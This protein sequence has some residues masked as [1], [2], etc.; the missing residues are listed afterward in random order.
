MV[1]LSSSQNHILTELSNSML[2]LPPPN[3]AALVTS[4]TTNS[5]HPAGT[6]L[7]TTKIG[8]SKVR[9]TKIRKI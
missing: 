4:N 7:P 8:S 2:L 9:L 5:S 3:P 6:L 1:P